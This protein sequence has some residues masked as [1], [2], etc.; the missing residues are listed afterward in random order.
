MNGTLPKDGCKKYYRET[1]FNN[2][3]YDGGKR[4]IAVQPGMLKRNMNLEITKDIIEVNNFCIESPSTLPPPPKEFLE[5]S[6]SSSM[7]ELVI[8]PP[9]EFTEK[10]K[11][12]P[13]LVVTSPTPTNSSS[14]TLLTPKTGIPPKCEKVIIEPKIQPCLRRTQSQEKHKVK[15]TEGVRVKIVNYPGSAQTSRKFKPPERIYPNS[16]KVCRKFSLN[17]SDKYCVTPSVK[18]ALHRSNGNLHSSN[19]NGNSSNN[20]FP[21]Q[22]ELRKQKIVPTNE[23]PV[24]Q[25]TRLCHIRKDKNFVNESIQSLNRNPRK[26]RL[27]VIQQ[28]PSPDSSPK[29]K[30]NYNVINI[31]KHQCGSGHDHSCICNPSRTT[32]GGY[33]C[34]CLERLQSGKCCLSICETSQE[35]KNGNSETT[36]KQ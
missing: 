17:E 21:K 5:L 26:G 24:F 3:D 18:F 19:D 8:P 10:T 32:T 4:V 35:V 15:S 31:P 34:A 23:S 28:S 27:H 20:S 9:F 6:P 30:G 13:F 22:P 14:N 2:N 11:N 1:S 16:T 7:K 33:E 25:A 36:K 12:V 29:E